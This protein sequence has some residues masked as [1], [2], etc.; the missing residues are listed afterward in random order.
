MNEEG[1]LLT[2]LAGLVAGGIGIVIELRKDELRQWFGELP[3][4]L[5]GRLTE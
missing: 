5:R 4:R 3:R 2:V 1:F